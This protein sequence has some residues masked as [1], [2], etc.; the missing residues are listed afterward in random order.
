LVRA[1]LLPELKRPE[2]RVVAVLFREWQPFEFDVNLKRATLKSLLETINNLTNESESFSWEG[3]LDRFLSGLNAKY[4]KIRLRNEADLYAKPL[5]WFIRECSAAFYRRLFFVFDQF[6]EYIYYHPLK[7]KGERFDAELARAINDRSVPASFLICLREDGLGKLNRLRGGVPDLLGNIIKLEHLDENGALE[8]IKKP[9][10]VFEESVGK[11]VELAPELVETLLK[12]VDADRLELDQVLDRDA[13]EI[14]R[15][16]VGARY[17]V[18]ALQAVLM[19]LWQASVE[20]ALSDAA[21]GGRKIV[22]SREAL[23]RLARNR[24]EGEDE[25]RF[26]VRRYFDQ[27]LQL[28][29]DRNQK[30]AAEILPHMVRIGSQKKARSVKGLAKESGIPE[31]EVYAAIEKLQ[32]EPV[33]LVRAVQEGK[34]KARFTS[35]STMSWLLRFRIGVTADGKR[36]ANQD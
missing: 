24:T 23:T 29:G 20:P 32:E 31:S 22:I 19:R 35:F 18:L 25:V 4:P 7:E 9:L 34:A 12:Q 27:Q 13:Q 8:A 2:H 1:G 28:L 15:A 11:T 17:K 10:R 14:R 36:I 5:D 3:F 16:D 21:R 6:E 30:N 33:N 26:V